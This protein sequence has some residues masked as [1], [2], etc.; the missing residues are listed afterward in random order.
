MNLE[1]QFKD[2]TERVKTLTQRP[3]NEELLKLYSL[4]QQGSEGDIS[5]EKPGMFDFVA[6]A[7]YNAWEKLKGTTKE[8]AMQQYIDEVNRLMAK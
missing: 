2:A 3:S 6:I 8:N 4:Y 1:E 5:G 7:K